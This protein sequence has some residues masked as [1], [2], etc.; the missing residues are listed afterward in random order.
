MEHLWV[1]NSRCEIWDPYEPLDA[2]LDEPEAA[3]RRNDFEF[4]PQLGRGSFGV[5]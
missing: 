1:P 2:P 3:G 5:P 4:G